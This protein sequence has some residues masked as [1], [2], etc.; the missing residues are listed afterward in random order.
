MATKHFE[1]G[2]IWRQIIILTAANLKSRYRKTI[3]GFLWVIINPLLMFWVQ[4]QIFI[5][6]MKISLTNYPLF[7]LSGLLPWLFMTQSLEM[8]ATIFN[9]MGS[10]L[11]AFPVHPFVFLAAQLID[12]F[13]NFIA[14][15]LVLLIPIVLF[16]SLSAVGLLFLP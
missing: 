4:S 13:I 16:S 2:V 8:S 7:L 14:A 6:V 1:I 10:A 12:N 15:F 5:K 11:K 3:A 9:Q